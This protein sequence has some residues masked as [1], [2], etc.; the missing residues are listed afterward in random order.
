MTETLVDW[1][2]ARPMPA[3]GKV[4]PLKVP[5][6]ADRTLSNGLRALA[7]RKPGVPRFEGRLVVPVARKRDPGDPGRQRLLAETLLSGLP[8]RD[9]LAIDKYLQ[10]LG[11]TLHVSSDAER[12]SVSFG[13]LT[14]NL[15][16]TLDLLGEVLSAATFP[17]EEVVLQ[18]ERV[19]Q[20]V[21]I[22][23]SQPATI[24]AEAFLKRL[25]GDHPYTRVLPEAEELAALDRKAV[26]SFANSRLLP[27]GSVLVLVGDINPDKA[28]GQVEA[29]LEAWN[30]PGS[31]GE[32]AKPTFL[33]PGPLTLVDRPDAVQTNIRVGGPAVLRG[34]PDLPALQVANTV[35]GGY[36]SSRLVE[37][38]R[39]RRGYTYGPRSAVDQNLQAASLSVSADVATEVT[40]PALMEIRYEL[41]R[42][43]TLPVEADE[44]QSAKRYIQGILA[45]QVQS[46][47]GM[48]S[49]LAN[50]VS[51][52]QPV[53]WLREFPAAIEKVTVADVHEVSARYLAPSR[54]I[55]VMVGDRAKVAPSLECLDSIAP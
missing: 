25:W 20:E 47:A 55:T 40:A 1:G 23:R 48:A 41:A 18:R 29:S 38:I 33:P 21:V 14:L 24:A 3:V 44:L 7:I 35:F 36:F 34:H 5:T 51:A 16:A 53:D 52:G 50:V 2:A 46:Q 43:A 13:G 8:D 37:N 22:I 6:V 9:A 17:E 49:Y 28:I 11:A 39:E 30:R 54:M 31:S 42:M 4:R 32:L 19:A 45:L 12:V 27:R 10:S 26:R 15:T